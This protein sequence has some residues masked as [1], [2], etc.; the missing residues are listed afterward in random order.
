[1]GSRQ[2]KAARDEYRIKFGSACQVCGYNRCLAA[3]EFHHL[4]SSQKDGR[5]GHATIREIK[6]HPE[7]FMLVCA[8]CHR[9][10]HHGLGA[11]VSDAY[12]APSPSLE[13]REG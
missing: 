1:M 5:I 9:E 6:H 12:A 11:Q 10:I 4:D 7:R 8:N 13:R 3:L 2:R